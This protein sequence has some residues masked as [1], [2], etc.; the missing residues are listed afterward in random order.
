MAEGMWNTLR[1]QEG[2]GHLPPA[3]SAGVDALGGR[4]PAPE[5]VQTMKA[6]GIDISTHLSRQLDEVMLE[7]AGEVICMTRAHRD[8]ILGAYPNM[9]GKV[10]LLTDWKSRTPSP[11][12][13]I[14]DPYG[15]PLAGYRVCFS[16]LSREIRRVVSARGAIH[17]DR[18]QRTPI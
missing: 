18:K 15:G 8:R 7:A 14:S 5:S 12:P 17:E 13:D 9:K 11:E 2:L 4:R 16:R 6:A 3:E 10:I 1:A